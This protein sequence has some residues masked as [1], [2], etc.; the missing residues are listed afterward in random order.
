MATSVVALF[1]ARTPSLIE[2]FFRQLHASRVHYL[3]I[4]FA[5]LSPPLLL[6]NL[7]VIAVVACALRLCVLQ[8]LRDVH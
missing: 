8:S 6:Y 7:R 1:A 3:C 2:P 4:L 5:Y